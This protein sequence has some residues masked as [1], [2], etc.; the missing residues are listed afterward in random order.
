S[1]SA[2]RVLEYVATAGLGVDWVLETH[3]HADHLA[4]G[5]WLAERTGARLG[6]GAGIVEVQRRLKALLDLDDAFATDGSQFDRLFADGDTFRVGDLEAIVMA[7]PG[8]TPDS[9]AY[10]IG[11]AVFVGDTLFA[12]ECGTARCD[13]PGGDAAKLY[14]SIR[15]LYSLPDSTRVYLCHD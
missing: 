15:S 6:I 14:R 2:Q 10:R 1:T 3:A 9:V 7:T 5:A 4:A 8:H 11:D 12:P 13:F